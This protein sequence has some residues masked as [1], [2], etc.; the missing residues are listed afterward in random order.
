MEAD[1][2]NTDVALAWLSSLSTAW[3]DNG[4][5]GGTTALSVLNNGSRRLALGSLLASGLI[6]HGVV[7]L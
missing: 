1:V 4:D 6:G 7:E 5:I 3:V 2:V